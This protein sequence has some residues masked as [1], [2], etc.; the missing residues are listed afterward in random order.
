MLPKSAL[1]TLS[2]SINGSSLSMINYHAV[3]SVLSLKSPTSSL[4]CQIF[5]YFLLDNFSIQRENKGD[6]R[7]LFGQWTD[8]LQYYSLM[9]PWNEKYQYHVIYILSRPY[10]I[11]WA[12]YIFIQYEIHT[13]WNI[14]FAL[15]FGIYF[16]CVLKPQFR[17]RLIKKGCPSI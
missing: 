17:F 1:W 2:S 7:I 11:E 13:L 5:W 9:K 3:F 14:F 10:D 12:F 4:V 16:P 15:T 8:Y 6:I